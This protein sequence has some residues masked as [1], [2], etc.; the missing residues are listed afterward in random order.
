MK[1]DLRAKRTKA[2]I[3]RALI[4][5]LKTK[6]FN[7]LTVKNIADRAKINRGTF[8]L[9]YLDKFDLLDQIE[10]QLYDGI[11][12]AISL[13]AQP[14]DEMSLE[15]INQHS[16]VKL[17]NY[18]YQERDLVRVLISDNGDPRFY[19]HAKELVKK[20]LV[21]RCRLINVEYTNIIPLDYAEELQASST[22]DLFAFWLKKP[23]P[24]APEKFAAILMKS[25]Q[26]SPY[27]LI[28]RIPRPIS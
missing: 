24:E 13:D 9:H 26:I 28:A 18:L 16:L 20:E 12:D 2:K 15:E 17:S 5:E 4:D 22:L 23:H 27:Q 7:A 25:R 11:R 6:S 14:I 10:Q 8:Y 21:D 1:N 19:P 3:K